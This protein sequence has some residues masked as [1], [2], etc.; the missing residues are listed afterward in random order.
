MKIGWQCETPT[1][2][3]NPLISHFTGVK[4][5]ALCDV[6]PFRSV[7]SYRQAFDPLWRRD[8]PSKRQNLFTGRQ[9]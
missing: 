4:I 7:E 8:H 2:C 1:W 3:F 5:W 9:S 6:T